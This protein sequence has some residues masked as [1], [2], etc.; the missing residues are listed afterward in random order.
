MAALTD[1]GA[2]KRLELDLRQ[3]N[4][5]L[6]EF[7]FVASHDLRAPLRGITDLVDWI[8]ADLGAT[9]PAEVVHNLG[10]IS[11]RTRR[12]EEVVGELLAYARA[13]RASEAPDRI[14]LYGLVRGILE[15]QPLPAGFEIDL[16]LDL[17]AL[18]GARIPLETALRNLLANAV[19]HHDRAQGRLRVVARQE[20]AC[21]DISVIDDGPGIPRSVRRALFEPAGAATTPAAGGANH[22][23]ALTKRLVNA[24]GGQI[25][26]VSPLADGRGCCFRI[27]WPLS[28]ED[29]PQ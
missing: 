25:A 28:S 12:L 2:R 9:A 20:G 18:Q 1:I 4:A 10:R 7:T 22:G 23:L 17:P 21:C 24:H 29:L 14:D 6:E 3:A 11:Q 15:M 26:L 27:S 13:G 19:Q 8:V 16:Q 5:D